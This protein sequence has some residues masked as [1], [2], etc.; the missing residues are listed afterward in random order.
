[1]TLVWNILSCLRKKFY[2]LFCTSLSRKKH[3]P[4]N[5][6]LKCRIY[7]VTWTNI[8][9]VGRTFE[10]F[11]SNCF[12]QVEGLLGHMWSILVSVEQYYPFRELFSS[13]V[14]DGLFNFQQRVAVLRRNWITTIC[15]DLEKSIIHRTTQK[16]FPYLRKQ[17]GIAFAIIANCK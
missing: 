13:I 14:S 1:M 7:E 9:D 6:I 5:D 3:C 2:R 4:W 16:N 17:K 15:D 8:K 10:E 11:P 12:Q